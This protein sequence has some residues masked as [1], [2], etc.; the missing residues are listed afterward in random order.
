M[1]VDEKLPFYIESLCRSLNIKSEEELNDLLSIFDKFNNNVVNANDNLINEEE[2]E[3]NTEKNVLKI[4]PDEVMELLKVFKA[5]K[6][7]MAQQHSK[8]YLTFSKQY[9]S[10][11]K[12]IFQQRRERRY[13]KRTYEL[14]I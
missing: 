5:E 3:E 11:F 13:Q 8:T 6:D 12:K 10:I 4:D 9:D 14:S 1:S 2:D 7:K